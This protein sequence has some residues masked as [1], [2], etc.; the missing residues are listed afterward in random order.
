M[1]YPLSILRIDTEECSKS[2]TPGRIGLDLHSILVPTAKAMM[3]GLHLIVA[4]ALLLHHHLV[5]V[6]HGLVHVTTEAGVGWWVIGNLTEHFGVA[7]RWASDALH[8]VG[9]HIFA[10]HHGIGRPLVRGRAAIGRQN[11]TG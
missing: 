2:S 7:G 6:P 3:N 10:L 9:G 4:S 8:T 1:I 11:G 5:H